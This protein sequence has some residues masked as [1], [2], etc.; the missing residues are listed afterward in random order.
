MRTWAASL[1]GAPRWVASVGKNVTSVVDAQ[2]R[3]AT[4]PISKARTRQL[5]CRTVS[6]DEA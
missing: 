1:G 5:P 4:T 3:S 2:L 6:N